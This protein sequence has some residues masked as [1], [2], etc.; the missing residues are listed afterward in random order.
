MA[1]DDVYW[2]NPTADWGAIGPDENP[3]FLLD[4]DDG[5]GP[6]ALSHEDA[7]LFE[8]YTIGVY[9]Y[10]RGSI[11]DFDPRVNVYING[12]LDSSVAFG[13]PYLS[14]S[15]PFWIVGTI[16]TSRADV[17]IEDGTPG[18]RSTFSNFP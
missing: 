6:E 16:Q 5:Y 9:L 15:E 13:A 18:T 3:V 11:S 8:E 7:S 10:D 12:T 17:F 2:F 14:D 1:P 4:D